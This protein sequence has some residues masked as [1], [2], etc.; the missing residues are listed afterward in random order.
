MRDTL[1]GVTRCLIEYH[2]AD[3]RV[4]NPLVGVVRRDRIEFCDTDCQKGPLTIVL[5]N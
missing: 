3:T 1:L 2:G 5:H 4:H